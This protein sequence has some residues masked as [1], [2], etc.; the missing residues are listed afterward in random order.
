MAEPRTNQLFVT[1][2][3]SKLEEV[4]KLLQSLDV[5]VR[6]VMIEARIVEASDSFGR[7]LGVRLGG[8]DLR[9]QKG[10]DGG[11]GLF[12]GNRMAIGT[13]YSN[14]TNSTGFG[15]PV[16]V[17]AISSTCLPDCRGLPAPAALPCRFSM[18]QPIVS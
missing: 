18:R 17:G 15:G 6:Q 10:G 12:G 14:A 8:G 5:P 7:S 9:A 1:D 11:Y 4:A 13:D 3:A 16:N 2:I